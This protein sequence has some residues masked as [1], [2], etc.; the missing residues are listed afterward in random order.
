MEATLMV[1]PSPVC[2]ICKKPVKLELATIDELGSA[3]HG[4][5]YFLSITGKQKPEPSSEEPIKH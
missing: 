3:V 4:G 1:T 2:R 5:C